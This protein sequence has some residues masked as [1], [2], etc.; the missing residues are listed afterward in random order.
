MRGRVLRGAA[1][2]LLVGV[3]RVDDHL[4]SDERR[5][6]LRELRDR[7]ERHREHD[8]LAE[9]GRIRRRRRRRVLPDTAHERCELV[10]MT[11]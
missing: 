6:I 8:D 3:A 1:V 7:V 5:E 2:A 9:R 4:A 11:R 10:G